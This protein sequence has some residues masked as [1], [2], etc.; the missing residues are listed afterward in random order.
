[1]IVGDVRVR[2][3]GASVPQVYL[4][5][6]YTSEPNMLLT[7]RSQP[8]TA[9]VFPIV[10]EAVRAADPNQPVFNVRSMDQVLYESV[11]GPRM[12]AVLSAIFAFLGI[13]LVT[14]GLYGAISY[15]VVS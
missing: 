9:G 15:V 10:R 3:F 1:G 11:S 14:T 6:R 13:S 8:R 7:V 4:S 12:L 5:Y 2:G